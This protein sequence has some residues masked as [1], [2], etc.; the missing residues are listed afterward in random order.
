MVSIRYV[1]STSTTSNKVR[2]ALALPSFSA[3]TV[4]ACEKLAAELAGTT[5]ESDTAHEAEWHAFNKATLAATRPSIGTALVLIS[6]VLVAMNTAI[7][8]AL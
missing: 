6:S 2:T 8:C 3:L 1:V 5:W 4:S 7:A